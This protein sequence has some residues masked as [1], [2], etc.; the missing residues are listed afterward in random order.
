MKITLLLILFLIVL[1]KVYS[2]FFGLNKESC[3]NSCS[4]GDYNCHKGSPNKKFINYKQG[5]ITLNNEGFYNLILA[6]HC[7]LIFWRRERDSNPRE[8]FIS[9]HFPG[10]RLKPLGH[11]SINI[12]IV[13]KF[14]LSY[15]KI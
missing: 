4:S 10:V 7:I 14:D 6:N 9:T 13:E 5:R 1:N 2:H 15:K 8:T 3:H 12:F 11:L